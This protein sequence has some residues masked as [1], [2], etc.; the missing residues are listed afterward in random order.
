M[1]RDLVFFL[2]KK[3]QMIFFLV[4]KLLV[5]KLAVA[6]SNWRAPVSRKCRMR[7]IVGFF[8]KQ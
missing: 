8:A 2:K 3:K 5:S 7:H 4:T 1:T 6:R